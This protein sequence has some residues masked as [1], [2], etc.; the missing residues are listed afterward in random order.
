MRRYTILAVCIMLLYASHAAAEF[1]RW[2]DSDGKE[3]FTNNPA[4]IP[5][6]Y[7]SRSL[8]VKIDEARVSVRDNPLVATKM[9]VSVKEHKDKYGRGEEYWHDKALN[10]RLKLH[11][12]QDEHDL[13]LKQ[14][15]GQDQK[16]KKN[17][18]KKNRSYSSVEK[19][20]MKL[21]KDIAKTR[22]MLE[23]DLPE[24]VHKAEA[25]EGWIRE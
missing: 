3:F 23:V 12:L 13:V 1:Y 15:E 21:E 16:P 18:S 5:Q 22:K 2:V 11:H 8:P 14:L 7:R 24:E 6:E 4:K 19:K 17:G 20:K 10:L 9:P 25:Y